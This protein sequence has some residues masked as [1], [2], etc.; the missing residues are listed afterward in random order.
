MLVG[1]V[2]A[3]GVIFVIGNAAYGARAN[4]NK[5][6]AIA[7]S[8]SHTF[9]PPPPLTTYASTPPH[10]T[11][12]QATATAAQTPRKSKWSGNGVFSVGSTPTGGARAAIPP[13][14][15][16]I[17]MTDSKIGVL[18]VIRCSD[19]PCSEIQNFLD[20]DTGFGDGYVSVIEILP[21]DGGVR[22]MNATLTAV[23]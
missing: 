17:E 22:L 19:L 6:R 10:A 21:S 5:A 15:Y 7:T 11:A 8:S 13:G 9:T 4:N 23:R 20:A 1:A 3:I 18:S 14:R 16:T 12:A 2:A